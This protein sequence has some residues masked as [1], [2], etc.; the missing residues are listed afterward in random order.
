MVRS[1]S[2]VLYS[3]MDEVTA[4]E[5]L[6]EKGWDF[7]WEIQKAARNMSNPLPFFSYEKNK[8]RDIS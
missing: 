7:P 5:T 2:V 4:S 3:L 1:D 8:V 6:Y